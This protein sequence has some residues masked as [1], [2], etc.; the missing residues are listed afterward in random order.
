MQDQDRLD[1]LKIIQ[2]AYAQLAADRRKEEPP[3]WGVIRASS[4]G[5]PPRRLAMQL[6]S[7]AT[8]GI[9]N[10]TQTFEPESFTDRTMRIFEIGDDRH[11]SLRLRMV[12]EARDCGLTLDRVPTT[13]DG[14]EEWEIPLSEGWIIR[15]HPDGVMEGVWCSA[16]KSVLPI[17]LLEIKTINTK[18]YK[19]FVGGELDENYVAQLHINMAALE[20]AWACVLAEC[21]DTQALKQRWY[22]YDRDAAAALFKKARA[23]AGHLSKTGASALQL[24]NCAETDPKKFGSNIRSIRL[25]ETKAPHTV[26]KLEW[27][28]SYCPF[29]KTCYPENVVWVNGKTQVNCHR[30]TVPHGAYVVEAAPMAGENSSWKLAP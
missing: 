28:C 20:I 16:T 1:P 8:V 25:E 12:T 30:D 29:W 10:G 21:K 13:K 9:P 27:G 23:V 17:A 18:G 2:R 26:Q 14:E 6:C 3:K 15:G 22:I 19:R 4:I 5:Y 11:D 7:P 24:P